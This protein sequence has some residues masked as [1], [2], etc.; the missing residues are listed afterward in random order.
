MTDPTITST[1][2][3][4]MALW[5]NALWTSHPSLYRVA[6]RRHI[7]QLY[8]LTARCLKYM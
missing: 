2:R 3:S 4:P 6:C 1:T 7:Y 8:T 5:Q